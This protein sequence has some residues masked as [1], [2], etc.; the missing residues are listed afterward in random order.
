MGTR[1]RAT[2]VS[3]LVAGLFCWAVPATVAQ[4]NEGA[5]TPAEE[6]AT[7]AEQPAA[8]D[9]QRPVF[10]VVD[11]DKIQQDYKEL[12][13]RQQDLEN[14]L[15][16][17]RGYLDELANF[18]FVSSKD[19]ES[20]AAILRK[21]APLSEEDKKRVAELR[22]ISDAKDKRYRELL[23]NPQ[24][25]PQEEEEYNSLYEIYEARQ[26]ELDE[27]GAQFATELQGMRQKAIGM[28]MPKVKNAIE[29][30]AKAQNFDYVFDAAIVFFG[31]VDITDSV[32]ARLNAGQPAGEETE[33][34]AQEGGQ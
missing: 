23:A 2:I 5:E 21:S 32:V 6:T 33:G 14:W 27:L 4:E 17:R 28:L 8:A 25:T 10:A 16:G 1:S 29:A 9:A 31:G 30:E 20:V 11:L 19:F 18:T 22:E 7:P 13:T 26:Q 12:R 34:G 24:R 15:A 3:L